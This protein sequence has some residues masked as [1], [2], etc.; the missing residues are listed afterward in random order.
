MQTRDDAQSLCTNI[1]AYLIGGMHVISIVA[2]GGNEN[3]PNRMEF[4]VESV[5]DLKNLPPCAPS[6]IAYTAGYAM[7]WH[8]SLSGEWVEV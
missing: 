1:G 4:L 3:Y 8:K 2:S 5:D 6:S 7:I